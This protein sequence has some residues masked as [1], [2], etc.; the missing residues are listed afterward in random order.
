VAQEYA[1]MVKAM[2]RAAEPEVDQRSAVIALQKAIV[3]HS[4][5]VLGELDDDDPQSVQRVQ[6]LLAPIDNFRARTGRNGGSGGSAGGST[7]E[8]PGAGPGTGEVANGNPADQ[9]APPS[10]SEE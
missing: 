2:G 5:R 1:D 6:Q 9:P 3:Q 7:S 4:S 8:G 10:S